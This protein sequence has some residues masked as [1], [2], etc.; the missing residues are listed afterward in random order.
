M[1]VSFNEKK[2]ARAIGRRW[3]VYL[4]RLG[5]DKSV[6]CL[7]FMVLHGIVMTDPSDRSHD[8]A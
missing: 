1:A 7:C 3:A 5:A 6:S 4:K 8:I 2:D